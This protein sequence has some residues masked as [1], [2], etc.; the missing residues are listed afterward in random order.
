MIFE[1]T[2]SRAAAKTLDN[3]DGQTEQRVRERIKQIASD[4]FDRRFSKALANPG[5]RRSSRVGGWRILFVAD[6]EKT[7]VEILAI[8][9]RGQI[10]RRL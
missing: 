2:L 4:P 1:V 5:G 6:V 7:L 10:Y 9:S 8:G 3:M